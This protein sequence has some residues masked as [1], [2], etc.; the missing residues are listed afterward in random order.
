ML[1]CW[2]EHNRIRLTFIGRGPVYKAEACE[3][4]E[5]FRGP[6]GHFG[7]R[8][9]HARDKVTELVCCVTIV[10][11]FMHSLWQ[12]GHADDRDGVLG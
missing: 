4:I 10:A 2:Q 12:P 8:E 6:M 11:F 5:R 9:T 7:F 1:P 3:T